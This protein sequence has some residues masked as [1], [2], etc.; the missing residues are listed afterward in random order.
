MKMQDHQKDAP[1]AAE[2][3]FAETALLAAGAARLRTLR[4]EHGQLMSAFVAVT[5]GA[6]TADALEQ[7]SAFHRRL[8]ELEQLLADNI[9]ELQILIC[10]SWHPAKAI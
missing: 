3:Y 6:A 4:R 7:A 5:V 8:T 10:P 1:G 9:E 2:L